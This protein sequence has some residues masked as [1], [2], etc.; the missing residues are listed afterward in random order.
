MPL[1]P[2]SSRSGGSSSAAAKARNRSIPS[3]MTRAET[4]STRPSNRSWRASITSPSGEV[5]TAMRDRVEDEDRSECLDHHHRRLVDLAGGLEVRREPLLSLP[6][7]D[8]RTS[9]S[10]TICNIRL[11]LDLDVELQPI[12]AVDDRA[13]KLE[14]VPSKRRAPGDTTAH[15]RP[16]ASAAVDRLPQLLALGQPIEH[17]K[18]VDRVGLAAAGPADQQRQVAQR[19]DR[20]AERLE[21]R[22][23]QLLYIWG[24]GHRAP[25]IVIQWLRPRRSHG[26]LGRAVARGRSAVPRS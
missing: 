16:L 3:L 14:R 2:T 9:C 25:I 18:G 11:H 12:L 19:Q 21:A 6:T 20:I 5:S 23:S 7:A 15:L 1:S 17:M 4:G 10:R 22:E 24:W 26:P 8:L 13:T